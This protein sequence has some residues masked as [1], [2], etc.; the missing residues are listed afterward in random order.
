MSLDLEVV[1]RQTLATSFQQSEVDE[2]LA[3]R[4]TMA[5][6]PGWELPS[7]PTWRE[8][9]FSDRNWMFQFHMLRWLEPLRR[10]AAKGDDAAYAMWLRWVQDWAAKNPPGSA[11]SRWAWTD[12]S[13]G[14]RAQQL[15]LAAPLVSE[16]SPELLEWLERTIRVHAEHLADPRNMGNANHALHQQESL[17]IAGRVLQEP[18]LWQLALERM[19]S[20]LTEQYDE[21]GV[22]AEGATAYHHN[23]Y[24]WWERTLERIDRE[25]LER[26]AGSDRHH[27]APV[28]IAHATRP[29]GTLVTIGDTDPMSPRAVTT[30]EVQWVTTDGAAGSPPTDTLRVYD[31]GYVFGRSGWGDAQRPFSEHAFFSL[32]FGPSDR[33]HGHPDGTSL[34]FSSAGVNWVVDPGKYQYGNSEPRDHFFSRGAHSVVSIVGKKP[35]RTANVELVR[36]AIGEDLAEFALV[37]DS[38]RGL[39]L[40]RRVVWSRTGEY[41]VI[42]DDVMSR[43]RV[44]AVQRWQLGPEVSVQLGPDRADLSA[45]VSSARLSFL[46]PGVEVETLRGRESPFDG[47]VSTGW[48]QMAPGS[49]VHAR[50]DARSPRFVTVLA[51]GRDTLPVARVHGTI[52][53]WDSTEPFELE[54]S[55]GPRTETLRILP[56]SVE[57]LSVPPR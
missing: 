1:A 15:C 48:K 30:P 32:R 20:L 40:T 11:R 54:V 13:D 8:D 26:P 49:V 34:T 44:R 35:Q 21:Q 17:F 47:W 2:L 52:G 16:R 24:L 51:T 43:R 55:S 31:S 36:A 22:N 27:E 53:A 56:E 42:V 7:D 4:L 37:D 28:E 46:S 12:M 14:I 10:A 38:Y 6:H 23:N 9:P 19:G 57:A 18:R 5:P 50:I 41:L 29:D 3:G 33:V 45:G 25:G 39:L